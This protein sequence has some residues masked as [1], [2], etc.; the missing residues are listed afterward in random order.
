MGFFNIIYDSE[1]PED[2]VTI[3]MFFNLAMIF[4]VTGVLF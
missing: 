2:I 4:H 3:E 1:V